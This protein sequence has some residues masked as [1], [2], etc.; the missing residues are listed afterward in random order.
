MSAPRTA[1]ALAREELTRSIKEVAR[2]HLREAGAA[3][4]SLRAVARELEMSSSAI[5][6]YFPSRDDLLTA[7]IVDAYDRLGASVERGEATPDRG[8]HADRW[9]A[10][11]RAVRVWALAHPHEYALVYGSPV[12]GYEAPTDTIAPAARAAVV[13]LSV[14]RDAG[15]ADA[16]DPPPAPEP[17]TEVAADLAALGDGL[18]AGLSAD[19]AARAV[20]AWTSVFG[21]VSFE[22][23]GQYR[24]VID[25]REAFFDHA[26]AGLGRSVG[27]PTPGT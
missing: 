24:N 23:F 10:A 14:V 17:P 1:R 15:A 2:R 20:V 5:Y 4:L 8:A 13:A 6:R 27:L 22:L 18:L 26:V 12:P 19:V 16:L 9:L 11:C 25:H 3:G 7:L 21:L